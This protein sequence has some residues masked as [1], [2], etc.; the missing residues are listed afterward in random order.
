MRARSE[1]VLLYTIVKFLLVLA[2]VLIVLASTVI[3]FRIR[4][5]IEVY[6]FKR[7][8]RRTT[9]TNPPDRVVKAY[10]MYLKRIRNFFSLMSLAKVL[11]EP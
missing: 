5:L 4:A 1:L 10:G 9:K 3:Y 2:Y 7:V 8:F 11:R 6:R